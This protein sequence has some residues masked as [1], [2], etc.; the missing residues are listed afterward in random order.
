MS[1]EAEYRDLPVAQLQESPTN[2]RRRFDARGLEELATSIRS[3]GILQPLLVRSVTDQMYEVIAGARRL[4]AARMAEKEFLPV[5]I[6]QLSDA[7]A[8]EAQAIENLQREEIH[9]LEEALAY[10]NMLELEGSLYSVASIAERLGKSPA[11]ITQHLRLTELIEPIAQAF[12]DDRIGVGHALEIAKLQPFEQERAF[13]AA[14]RSA[15]NGTTNT[16]LLVPVRDLA[17]WIEQNILLQL[18]SV[19]FDKNDPTLVPEAG[20]CADCVKRTG[21]NTL[22]FGDATKDSC[23]DVACFSQKMSKFIEQEVAAKPN[24]VQISTNFGIPSTDSVLRRGKYMALQLNAKPAK[25]SANLAA[26]QKPCSH[27]KDAIVA[28]GK[29]RGQTVKVCTEPT[30]TIHFADRRA[31]DPKEV[32]KQKEQRRKE[33]LKRKLEATFRHRVLA[34]VLRKVSAPLERQDL[35]LVLQILLDRADPVRRETL[36]RRHKLSLSQLTAPD[37]VRKELAYLLRRLDEN[38]LSKMLMEWLLLDEVESVYHSEPELL[39][40]AARQYKVDTAKVRKV[41][42]QEIAAKEAKTLAKQNKAIQKTK[43]TMPRKKMAAAKQ[44]AA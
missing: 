3:Q 6:V 28:E 19:P 17:A 21:Y 13:E 32:A 44:V 1:T 15:W 38:G 36:A 29:E 34:E 23:S 27:M 25:R 24:L 10:K 11:Y 43:K 42:E 8:I 33:L 20:S 41:V 30:C 9:P 2:P 26:F 35:F 40:Q 12:L 39:N 16:R 18:D 7:E 14:F 37:K 31:P 22:L 4:R 5:R